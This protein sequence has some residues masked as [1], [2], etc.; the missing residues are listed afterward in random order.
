MQET[1]ESDLG[2]LRDDGVPEASQTVHPTGNPISHSTHAGF[3]CPVCPRRATTVSRFG[4][5]AS[6]L[7]VAAIAEQERGVGQDKNPPSLVGRSNVCRSKHTPLRI[8]PE[9]G[10]ITEDSVESHRNV[11]CDVLQADVSWSYHANDP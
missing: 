1:A 4:F 6:G 3:N 7:T 10:K 5:F 8:E 11:A 9:F 2:L